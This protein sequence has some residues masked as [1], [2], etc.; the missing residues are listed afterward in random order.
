MWQFIVNSCFKWEETMNFNKNQ[1]RRAFLKNSAA[2]GASALAAST[3][4]STGAFASAKTLKVGHIEAP[5]SATQKAYEAFAQK[6]A[7]RTNG[8]VNVEIYP[9]GQLG[10]LRDLYEGLRFGSVEMTSSGPDYVSNLVPVV[11]AGSLYYLWE[12]NDHAREMLSGANG[13]IFNKA[14]IEKAQIRNLAWGN[15]GF[16]SV[17]TNNRPIETPEDLKGLKIR[18]PEAKLHLEPMKAFGALPV[19]VPY[20]EVYTSLQ[21]DVVSGAEG[22]PSAVL[23]QKFNEVSKYYSLTEHLF[24]PLMI[25]ISER[26]YQSLSTAEQ[27]AVTES[28]REAWADEWDAAIVDNSAALDK[29]AAGGVVINRPDKAAFAEI[30][31]TSWASVLDPVGDEAWDIVKTFQ[32]KA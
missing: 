30:A 19:G 12:S 5:N 7:E 29:I 28:A 16:R 22:V 1:S 31:Q 9:A 11:V 14:L 15:L 32:R 13:A 18:V 2:A 26:F 3:L 4:F 6:V 25:T 20:A 17:F 10:G 8:S 21:T 24:N 23:Q 27:E